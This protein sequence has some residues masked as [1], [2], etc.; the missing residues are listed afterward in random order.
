M[1]TTDT[2]TCP[3]CGT[4]Y[5]AGAF[6]GMCPHCL[7]TGAFPEAHDLSAETAGSRIDRFTL[8]EKIGEGGMGS[9]W[10]A[11]QEE[12]VQR[13]VALKLIK[14]GMD[15]QALVARFEAER[16]V[17]AALDH[18]NIAKVFDAGTTTS[19][20]PY[21]AMEMAQGKSVT[22]YC[23]E[24]SLDVRARLD[25]FTEICG[26]V[27]HAHQKGIIHRDL[28]PSNILVSDTGQIKV[29]DFGVAKAISDENPIEATLLTRDHQL[30]GTPGYMS[31]EQASGESDIDTRAD[32]YSL[33]ALLYEMLTGGPPFDHE[34]LARAGI[35]EVVRT[36]REELPP[37]PSTRFGDSD[38]S[39]HHIKGD[40]DW[41]VMQALAK[42]RDRRYPTVDALSED[43]R[44]H[45]NDEP[46]NAAAPSF[47]YRFG[48]FARKNRLALGAAAAVFTALIVGGIIAASQAIRAHRAQQETQIV[49]A[50]SLTE[51]GLNEAADDDNARAKLWFTQ[52]SATAENDPHRVYANHMRASTYGALAPTP[53]RSMFAGLNHWALEDSHPSLPFVILRGTNFN[54]PYYYLLNVDT[55]KPA[56]VDRVYHDQIRALTF[57]PQRA[58]VAASQVIDGQN[59]IVFYKF[60]A[61]EQIPDRTIDIRPE[62]GEVRE[63]QFSDDATQLRATTSTRSQIVFNVDTL[64]RSEAR[65]IFSDRSKRNASAHKEAFTKSLRNVQGPIHYGGGDL[66]INR[67]ERFLDVWRWPTD[68]RSWSFPCARESLP[69]FDHQSR[70]VAAFGKYQQELQVYDLKERVAVGKLI[71]SP[72]RFV[73]SASFVPGAEHEI[74]VGFKAEGEPSALQRFNWLS[75][76]SLGPELPVASAPW[77]IHSHPDHSWFAVGCEKGEVLKVFPDNNTVERL[78]KIAAQPVDIIRFSEDGRSLIAS[79]SAANAKTAVW[80]I[81]E[82]KMRFPP[83][84]RG[85]VP[86]AYIAV[87]GG[88]LMTTNRDQDDLLFRDLETGKT[89][90]SPINN[91]IAKD[92]LVFGHDADTVLTCGDDSFVRVV[93]WRSGELVCPDLEHGFNGEHWSFAIPGTPW[94]AITGLR[95]AKFYDSSSGKEIAP[96]VHWSESSGRYFRGSLISPDAKTIA[97]AGA[98]TSIQIIDLSSLHATPEEV[99]IAAEKSDPERDAIAA[100]AEIHNGQL[101]VINYLSEWRPRFEKLPPLALED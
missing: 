45:L 6:A 86:R 50:D 84:D 1:S 80:D 52:A 44:R 69:I 22:D 72:G 88:I 14:L 4:T 34:T 47:A 49:L 28:K 97:A 81:A 68:K 79:S 90:P 40:L 59:R 66:L 17:L 56:L 13:E 58:E 67:N 70:H 10:R 33:G 54:P 16:Q 96:P 26:A 46:V 41:I 38:R 36:I 11:R 18:Q 7:I 98:G 23:N 25:L 29:I 76:E 87:R 60:P 82:G 48:K 57:H 3:D 77:A 74:I 71:S 32:V 101:S 75:G 92:N 20:R 100:G 73:K 9:V 27:G 89:I 85:R 12:P 21:F 51:L 95:G 93:R 5:P 2:N 55:G 30:V 53:L 19:G 64:E 62:E 43:I 61:A 65:A 42:E 99:A 15:T 37:K 31:P 91:I 83:I 39:N 24:Q 8:I 63:L 78:F 94:I 35:L